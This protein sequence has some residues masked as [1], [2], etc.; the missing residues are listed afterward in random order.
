MQMIS[1]NIYLIICFTFQEEAYKGQIAV[2]DDTY[3]CMSNPMNPTPSR[4][5]ISIPSINP[6][7]SKSHPERFFNP[8]G[9]FSIRMN[10]KSI[11][12]YISILFN[13]KNHKSLKNQF[14]SISNGIENNCIQKLQIQKNYIFS[15]V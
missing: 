1:L 14:L 6:N 2:H 11:R 8:F 13:H 4:T 10:P 3:V 12:T 7:E 9:I 5:H 15:L